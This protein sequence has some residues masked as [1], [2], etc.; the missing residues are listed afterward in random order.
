MQ[1]RTH[2]HTHNN[3]LLQKWQSPKPLLI[4]RSDSLYADAQTDVATGKPMA[5]ICV[6]GIDDQSS[7]RFTLIHTVGCTLHRSTSRV[8]HRTQF[9]HTHTRTKRMVVFN[10]LIHNT[11]KYCACTSCLVAKIHCYY[12]CSSSSYSQRSMFDTVLQAAALRPHTCTR[13]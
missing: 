8:I 2:V 12:Y 7:L 1:Q 13:I 9:I 10:R 5:A 11:S 6:Q 3:K 4:T